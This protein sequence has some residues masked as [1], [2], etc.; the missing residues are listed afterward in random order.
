MIFAHQTTKKPLEFQSER[1]FEG[2]LP[3]LLTDC[4][5]SNHHSCYPT[6]LGWI[7]DIFRICWGFIY[8]NSRKSVYRWTGRRG[9]CPCQNASDSGR[10]HETGCDAALNFTKPVR[11]RVVCPL[12]KPR[13]DG[14]LMCSVDKEDVR[15]FWGR[16]VLTAILSVTL[17]YAA[18][19]LTIFGFMHQVGYPISIQMIAWPP[20]WSEIN[21]AKSQYFLQNAQEAFNEGELTETVMSLSLAYEYDVYNYEAG[22]FLARLW[23]AN[24]PEFSNHLYQ[25]LI[26]HHPEHR[27][28]TAQAWLRSLL[29][30]ADYHWIEKLAINALRFGD[31]SSPAWLN[32]FLF[33]NQRTANDTVIQNLLETPETLSPGVETVLRWEQ[34][35]RQSPPKAAR[36]FLLQSPPS[37][38]SDFV[39]YFQIRLL[40][41]MGFPIDAVDIING[42]KNPLSDR[43]RIT[44]ELPALAE[45]NFQRSY[46]KLF[47]N[48][49]RIPPS[50]GQIDI[51]ASH[52]IT[53][54]NQEYYQRTKTLLTPARL[55]SHD[56]KLPA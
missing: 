33:S 37:N 26:T 18:L 50:L 53:H 6:V 9:V 45:A 32:A 46:H 29:P 17:F 51:L 15:S 56:Q 39:Y 49:L 14:T 54:P 44:L 27:I 8:W 31:N 34:H 35:I 22:F 4:E 16:V 41:S 2:A 36:E 10:A 20:K 5:V 11:F 21:Q 43:D 7:T 28:Q 42:G 24:R 40:I 19:V 55:S 23:Q 30:R 25:E 3:A 12:L 47:D 1:Q 52:L 38:S 13:A 48:I